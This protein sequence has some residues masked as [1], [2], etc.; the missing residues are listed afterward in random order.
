MP[1]DVKFDAATATVAG[2]V[3]IP[4][5]LLDDCLVALVRVVR[6]LEGDIAKTDSGFHS[7]N[8]SVR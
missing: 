6:C 7:T 5:Q 3:R 1:P 4:G 8:P 2:F